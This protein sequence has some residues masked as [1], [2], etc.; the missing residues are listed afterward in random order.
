MKKPVLTTSAIHFASMIAYLLFV[1]SY[2]DSPNYNESIVLMSF[3]LT[4]VVSAIVSVWV[5]EATNKGK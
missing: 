3:V 2:T 5:S 1:G 4:W